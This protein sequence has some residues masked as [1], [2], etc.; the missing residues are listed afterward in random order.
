MK[1]KI[2]FSFAIHVGGTK[3]YAVYSIIA[4]DKQMVVNHYGPYKEGMEHLPG[5]VGQTK[6][7]MTNNA[8]NESARKIK[9]KTKR[10]YTAW[11]GDVYELSEDKFAQKM[12]EIFGV[13]DGMDHMRQLGM[14]PMQMNQ[15]PAKRPEPVFESSLS[16]EEWGQW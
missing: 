5:A 4:R 13:A 10:G 6:V 3:F 14:T 11:A 8:L 16:N 7:M 15:A 12:L 9:E 2:S 1:Y